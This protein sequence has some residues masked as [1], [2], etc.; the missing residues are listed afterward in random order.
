MN[1]VDFYDWIYC[2]VVLLCVDVYDG[3]EIVD[4]VIGGG[5]YSFLGLFFLYFVIGYEYLD[6]V[7]FVLVF[8]VLGKICGCWKINVK[9]VVM[10]FYVWWMFGFDYF[11]WWFVFVEYFEIFWCYVVYFD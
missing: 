3:I 4:V 5:L 2:F 11:D 6:V 1:V 9:C 10:Y 7:W 8:V